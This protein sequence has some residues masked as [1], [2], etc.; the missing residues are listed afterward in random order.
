MFLPTGRVVFQNAWV[1][2]DVEATALNWVNTF[3]IGP[4]FV[5]EY[6]SDSLVDTTYRG[7]PATM[8]MLVG[9][10]QAGPVQIELIQPLGDGPSAYRDTVKPGEN[11]FHHMCV[12]TDNLDAD[13]AYYAGRGCPTAATGRVLD[14]A[15]FAYVDSHAKLNCMIEI[16]E[17]DDAI[18]ALFKVIADTCA[19]WDGKN[20]I[21]SFA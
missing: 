3:N 15:R 19:S 8:H 17:H 21:R 11:K 6:S 12:W 1:V 14:S 5:S 16:L 20:P 4:F 9:L 13:L 7:Q 10:A 18:A 2:D